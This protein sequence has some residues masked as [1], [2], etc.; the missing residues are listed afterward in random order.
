M[1]VTFGGESLHIFLFII[2]I[3]L[4]TILS[5]YTNQSAHFISTYHASLSGSQAMWTNQK[6]HGHYTL[7]PE[8][9]GEV[10]HSIVP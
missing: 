2:P 10:K 6:Y 3:F 8:I 5:S 9:I 1:A 4:I 7:P